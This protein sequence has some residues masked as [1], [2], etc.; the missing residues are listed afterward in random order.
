MSIDDVIKAAQQQANNII[1]ESSEQEDEGLKVDVM[2]ED[3]EITETIQNKAKTL[4]D[5]R[6]SSDSNNSDIF[7]RKK[8][9]VRQQPK[10]EEKTES[11]GYVSPYAWGTSQYKSETKQETPDEKKE[12][13]AK[14]KAENIFEKAA[15]HVSHQEPQAS[16]FDIYED[17]STKSMK[18]NPKKDDFAESLLGATLEGLKVII[19]NL[20]K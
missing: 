13:A 3:K 4:I 17:K 19:E 5:E 8:S 18:S 16:L 11:H 15:K 10:K 1:N 9:V 20:V 2:Q 7:V 12:K 6:P 14:E